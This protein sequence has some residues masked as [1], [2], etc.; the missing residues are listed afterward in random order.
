M[1]ILLIMDTQNLVIEL[2]KKG[3]TQPEIASEIG[4]SQPTISDIETGKIGKV[5]PS[6]KIVDGLMRLARA[7][8]IDVPDEIQDPGEE[9]Q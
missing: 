2:K 8:G 1:S 9:K 7:N 3:L 6:W 4:C 5:R